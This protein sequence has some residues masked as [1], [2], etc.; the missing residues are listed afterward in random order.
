MSTLTGTTGNDTLFGSTA[1]EIVV[2]GLAGDDRLVSQITNTTLIGNEGDDLL[3]L[4]QGDGS[5]AVINPGQGDDTVSISGMTTL[6]NLR[7]SK[8]LGTSFNLG[9]DVF[10]FNTALGSLFLQ[11]TMKAGDGDDTLNI[12]NGVDMNGATIAMNVGGDQIN[13]SADTAV[14]FANA[15]IGAG[16]GDD[17]AVLSFDSALVTLNAFTINGGEGADTVNLLANSGINVSGAT[18]FNL[19]GGHDM[20]SATLQPDSGIASG[21]L[22][23]RGDSGKDTMT[24]NLSGTVTGNYKLNVYGDDASVAGTADFADL[25]K[26]NW[27][28]TAADITGV[29]AGGGGADVI[30]VSAGLV[31]AGSANLSI[32]GG[33]G[34]DSI[35]LDTQS[36][37]GTINGGD[38]ADTIQV[39]GGTTSYI[40]G[41]DAQN[42]QGFATLLGGAGNDTFQHTGFNSTGAKG[43]TGLAG[44]TALSVTV[45]DMV[46]GDIF[47]LLGQKEVNT[48][49]NV[50]RSAFATGSFTAYSTAYGISG[51]ADNNIALFRSGDDVILQILVGSGDGSDV[52]EDTGTDIGMAVVRFKGNSAF[53]T[54]IDAASGQ[55]SAIGFT[56]SQSLNGASFNF[57]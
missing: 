28:N 50:V 25:I 30:A 56:F 27:S 51:F 31:T 47:K 10:N 32:D 44:I 11:G 18:L 19:G 55:L 29:I 37:A 20:F 34:A 23:F 48:G 53:G 2:R 13:V 49:A 21:S 4:Q 46:T 42:G 17:S 38:G 16:K 24:V 12:A 6:T 9:D 22:T 7:I 52:S 8:G 1:T 35:T 15:R 57:T 43:N 33:L 3:E 26:V 54:T 41:G 14:L 40:A 5:V 45:A 39:N 36:F